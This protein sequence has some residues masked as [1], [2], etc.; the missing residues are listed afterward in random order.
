MTDK[1]TI[2]HLEWHISHA[3]NFTCEN[4]CH[5]SN[6]KF[7][8]NVSVEE[9]EGWYSKWSHR[10]R[11]I[12]VDILG[13]E[14]LLNKDICE[15]VKITRDHWPESKIDIT[16]NGVLLDRFAD[17]PEYL[18][19]YNVGLKI[20]KHG[21]NPE[22][23]ELWESIVS[24]ANIWQQDYGISVNL[25]ES[26]LVW[27]KSYKGFG[28][29]IE[30]FEDNDPEESWKNCIT[31]Q[32]C[33]QIYNGNIYKCAPLAYLPMLDQKYKLSNKWNHYLTY[34]PLTPDCTDA[35]LIDFFNR[36]AESFCAMCPKNPQVLHRKNDPRA[37]IKIYEI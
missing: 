7:S 35:E 10:L 26:D 32:D 6:H 21:T 37:K 29:N 17:L 31:G 15:I 19:K 4:C 20:S 28:K 14:P 8:D 13:G 1:L 5:Y 12:T 18:K 25:W 23:N 36:K 3:C 22:Y 34:K 33:W 9:L 11:P 27:F 16:T 2:S 24:T 30:P